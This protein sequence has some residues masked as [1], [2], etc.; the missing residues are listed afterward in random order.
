V[1]GTK[2]EGWELGGR[3][4]GSVPRLCDNL[5]EAS[6]VWE[7]EEEGEGEGG[8]KELPGRPRMSLWVQITLEGTGTEKPIKT[9]L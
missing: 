3:V 5:G 1:V 7:G 6:G 4:G 2:D 8:H 9:L